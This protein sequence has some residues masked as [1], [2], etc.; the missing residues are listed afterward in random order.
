MVT[1]YNTQDTHDIIHQESYKVYIKLSHIIF[2]PLLFILKRTYTDTPQFSRLQ[3]YLRNA[4]TWAGKDQLERTM[5]G[6]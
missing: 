1:V 6:M 3:D 5:L 2:T 4:T